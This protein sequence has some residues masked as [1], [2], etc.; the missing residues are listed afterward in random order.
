[1]ENEPV[2]ERLYLQG[3]IKSNSKAQLLSNKIKPNLLAIA[4]ENQTLA[5]LKRQR[6]LKELQKVQHAEKRKEAEVFID[7]IKKQKERQQNKNV[8]YAR[9]IIHTMYS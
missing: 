2:H 8:K 3:A 7:K 4:G 5:N 9:I 1:L 6:E